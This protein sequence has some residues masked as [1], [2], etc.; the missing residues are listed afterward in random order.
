MQL[1]TW[2]DS[3]KDSPYIFYEVLNSQKI[4]SIFCHSH[5]INWSWQVAKNLY[6]DRVIIKPLTKK[7]SSEKMQSKFMVTATPTKQLLRGMIWESVPGWINQFQVSGLQY[8]NLCNYHC[9]APPT[10]FVGDSSPELI[11]RLGIFAT[12]ITKFLSGYQG[13]QHRI[14]EDSQLKIVCGWKIYYCSA[15]TKPHQS[16]LC[17]T[18][19]L[20]LQVQDRDTLI[21]QSAL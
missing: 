16:P 20:T 2:L 10:T 6:G 1:H 11:L 13:K 4:T 14:V 19:G 7:P 17:P 3:Q 12:W 15:F 8:K 21:V 5:R 9:H 18:W